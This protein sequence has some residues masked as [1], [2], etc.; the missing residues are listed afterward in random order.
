MQE[1]KCL[2]CKEMKPLDMFNERKSSPDGLQYHCRDCTKAYRDRNKVVAEETI[3]IKTIDL[4]EEQWKVQA[5]CSGSDT[6][7]FFTEAQGA[8]AD[9]P[10][11]TRICG[12][13]SVQKEC[14]EYAIKYNMEGW[15]A[16][17]TDQQRRRIRT[18]RK[19]NENVSR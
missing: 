11:L 6:E 17:T 7:A 12:A 10:M 2:N 15:W 4:A 8:Y 3:S 1:K 19:Y 13:C 5:N 14:L 18:E 16:N 9:R